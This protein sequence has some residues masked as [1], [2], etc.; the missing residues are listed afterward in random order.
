MRSMILA[1]AAAFA[2]AAIASAG[3]VKAQT[4][5]WSPQKTKVR[6]TGTITLTPQ[7]GF[8]SPFQCKVEFGL[9]TGNV[10]RGEDALPQIDSGAVKGKGC[11]NVR[12]LRLPWY[13]GAQ[14]MYPN[15]YG[16]GSVSAFGWDGGVEYCQADGVLFQS[17]P[18]GTW[19]FNGPC[20]SGT[21]ASNPPVTIIEQP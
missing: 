3:S 20:I 17:G 7:G 11:E 1:L 5:E 13:V 6:L 2:G 19:F 10:K 16:T 9:R 14:A 4:Y 18:D 12:L 8:G 21:L 15:G